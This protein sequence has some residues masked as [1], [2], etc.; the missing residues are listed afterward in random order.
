MS[1]KEHSNR[2]WYLLSYDVRDAKR[3]RATYKILRGSGERVQY[4]LFRCHLTRTELEALRWELEKVLEDEDD[5][6]V[7]HLCPHCAGGVEVRGQK[8]KWD[9]P[10]PRFR[11]L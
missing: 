3:L 4:S 7:I 8:D 9:E 5:L 6:L 2:H 10:P 11:I 1:A